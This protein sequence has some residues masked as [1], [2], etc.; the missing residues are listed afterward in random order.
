MLAS[1]ISTI[2]MNG[3]LAQIWGMING[4]QLFMHFP[5]MNLNPPA[6]AMILVEKLLSVFT[7]DF[8]W[9]GKTIDLNFVFGAWFATPAEDKIYPDVEGNTGRSLRGNLG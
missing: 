3:C 5:S 2:I 4:L 7:F 9:N 1:T 8:S 6:V